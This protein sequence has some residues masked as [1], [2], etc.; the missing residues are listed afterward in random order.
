MPSLSY[1]LVKV[2]L[3]L[4]GVKK[5]FSRA[6][7]NVEQLRKEDIHLPSKSL[8]EGNL[9]TSFQLGKATITELTPSKGVLS[10]ALLLYCPGGAF[11]YG[12]TELNWKTVSYLV[13]RTRIKAWL[14]DYPKAPEAKIKEMAATV[15][16]VYAE[17]LKRYTPSEIV[18]MGDSVG[19][20]L[21]MSLVQRL[22]LSGKTPPA[23]L[24]ALSPVLD[25]SMTNPEIKSIDK[26]DLILSQPGVLSAKKMCAG[27]TDLK[28]PLLSPLYGSFK[29]FPSTLIFVAE[30]DIMRPDEEL[31]IRKMQAEKVDVE[32]VTGEGMPHIWPLLPVM[33]EA[34]EALAKVESV[35]NKMRVP[36][37]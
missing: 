24:I 18:L 20:N 2:I 23:K 29:G 37:Q 10:D 5:S 36:V 1:Q 31:A 16:A 17:A 9:S 22:L 25:A 13:K 7:V 3:K 27:D 30:N 33:S 34:K 15:D 21:L 11:V 32:V 6:P 26:R 4:K 14:I 28:D 8:L 12:P 35:L 19:G